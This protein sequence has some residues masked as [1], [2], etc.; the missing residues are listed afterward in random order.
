M[1]ATAQTPAVPNTYDPRITFAPLTMPDPVNAYRS[2]NGAP[3]PSYWQNQAD[4]EMHADL[5]TAAKELKN[6]ETITYTNNSPDTLPSLWLHLEQNI[7]RKD[8]RSK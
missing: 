5:D 7:Y 8:S 6:A 2:G 1:H 4:Y 3:G